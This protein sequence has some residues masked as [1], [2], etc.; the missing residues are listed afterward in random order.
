VCSSRWQ[1]DVEAG[2]GGV[3]TVALEDISG[4]EVL[5]APGSA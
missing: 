2:G 5:E 1:V 3:V 4:E